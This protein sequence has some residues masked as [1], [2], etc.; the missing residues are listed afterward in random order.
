LAFN[1]FGDDP[2]FSIQ[3]DQPGPEDIL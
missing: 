2:D 3:K 1:E